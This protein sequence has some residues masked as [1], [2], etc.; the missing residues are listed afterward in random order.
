MNRLRVLLLTEE[1]ALY[2]PDSIDYILR[3]C[4]HEILEVC[5]LL[6]PTTVSVVK[7]LSRFL[8]A[9]GLLPLFTYARHRIPAIFQRL[10]STSGIFSVKDA[11]KNS[12]FA[13]RSVDDANSPE[14]LS[15]VQELA[16]DLIVTI[17][18]TQILKKSILQIPRLGIINVHSSFLPRHRGLYPVYWAMANGDDEVGV[19]IHHID[20]GIDTGDVL[21]Q[22]GFSLAGVATLHDAMKK[23]KALG[24]RL[25]VSAIDGIAAGRLSRTTTDAES[26]SYHS[27]P[28]RTSY[29]EFRRY[30]YR[31]W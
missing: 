25:M 5:T 31:L 18:P 28:D 15:R 2:L 10:L 21:L 22:E 29:R 24:A 13:Y 26:G 20:E 19:S 27:F 23:A 16:P 4:Q 8:R 30:G 6:N 11:A 7:N 3:N 14:F 12:G 9:F 17:S 1:D